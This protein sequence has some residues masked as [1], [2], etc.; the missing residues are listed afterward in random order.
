MATAV[1]SLLAGTSC[2]HTL[3]AYLSGCMKRESQNGGWVG[4]LYKSSLCGNQPTGVFSH[5][6]S[7]SL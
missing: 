3:N 1:C 2:S 5:R 7:G 6:N 4:L